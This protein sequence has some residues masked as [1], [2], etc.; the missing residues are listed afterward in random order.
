MSP[1]ERV[2]AILKRCRG[3]QVWRDNM[4][5]NQQR[6]T[7]RVIKRK[8][9]VKLSKAW[10]LEQYVI[11]RRSTASI[12][13]ERRCSPCSVSTALR[14]CG[15]AI[16]PVNTPDIDDPERIA[17]MRKHDKPDCVSYRT[18]L[19]TAFNLDTPC[20]CEQGCRRYQAEPAALRIERVSPLRS[21]MGWFVGEDSDT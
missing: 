20:V 15:I 19:T 18:C 9:R 4:A 13:K 16:R 1:A 2:E 14:R 7:E 5:I 17:E 6:N 10:L 3:R 12:G 8:Q 11:Q 21:A